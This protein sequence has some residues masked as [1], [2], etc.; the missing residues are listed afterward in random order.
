MLRAVVLGVVVLTNG[1]GGQVEDGGPEPEPEPPGYRKDCL[2]AE[3]E[4]EA[5]RV[6]DEAAGTS[7]RA[8]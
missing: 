4:A 2:P 7:T 5:I 8:A 1:V 3:A 6:Q